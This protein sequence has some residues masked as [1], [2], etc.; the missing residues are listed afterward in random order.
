VTK[1]FDINDFHDS[2]DK[3]AS[4]NKDDAKAKNLLEVSQTSSNE[5]QGENVANK[6]IV[7]K[8][9]EASQKTLH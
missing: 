7:F 3:R 4:L 1:D 6:K 5:S 2:K 8:E 9:S